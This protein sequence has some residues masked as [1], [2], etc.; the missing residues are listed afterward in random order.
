M[1]EHSAILQMLEAL[2]FPEKW[3][4]WMQAIL[5]SGSSTVILNG[6]PGKQFL[7][8]RGVRQGDP[9]SPLLFVLAAELLQYVINQAHQLGIL[10]LP[11]PQHGGSFPIVQ[12]A[13]DTLLV[14][15]AT[16]LPEG[17]A[18]F[19]LASTG[20]KVNF[21]KSSIVPINV[22]QD[23]MLVLSNTFGCQIGALPFTYLGLPLGTTKPRIADFSPLIDKIE[24]RLSACSVYQFYSGHLE[25]VN[26]VITPTV[27]YAMSTFKLHVGLIENIDR[28]R[29]Q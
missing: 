18:K 22:S 5:S 12:Y 23:K 14:M 7:C 24:R 17:I 6:V 28:A 25:M 19:F 26:S 3:I 16:L 20:L 29:K 4:R 9:L 1:V 8:K 27:T 2:S 15:Q 10:A 21:G 13:D 11:I